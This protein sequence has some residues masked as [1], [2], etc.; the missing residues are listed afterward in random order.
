MLDPI[1]YRHATYTQS[2]VPIAHPYIGR[3]RLSF[4]AEN[5]SS[6]V[7]SAVAIPYAVG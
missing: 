6:S 2:N 4:C 5:A 3:M 7:A 1:A